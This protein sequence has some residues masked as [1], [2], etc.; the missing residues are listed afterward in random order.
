[1]DGTLAFQAGQ[2]RVLGA[3]RRRGKGF[4]LYTV[5][6]QKRRRFLRVLDNWLPVFLTE[7]FTDIFGR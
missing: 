3:W 6:A 1:M 5:A 7:V 2:R 4:A